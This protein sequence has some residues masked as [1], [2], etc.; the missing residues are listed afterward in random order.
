MTAHGK[1]R[2]KQRRITRGDIQEVLSS[3]DVIERYPND[4]PRPS[5]LMVGWRGERPLHVVAADDPAARETV[6]ITAYEPDP[7]KWS[8]DF[9]RRTP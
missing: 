7:Q 3:G 5:Y 2:A 6:I 4:T 1:Q 8:A 9:K